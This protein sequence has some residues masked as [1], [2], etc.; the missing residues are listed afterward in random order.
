[1]W[2]EG[3][4]TDLITFNDERHNEELHKHIQFNSMVIP[5]IKEQFIKI[6]KKYWDCFCK[7]GLKRKIMG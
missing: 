3:S 6:G 4:C 1:M 5:E 7:E 2:E